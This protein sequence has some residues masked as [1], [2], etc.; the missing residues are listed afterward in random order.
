MMVSPATIHCWKH[1][2]SPSD[3]SCRPHQVRYA[4][5][6]DEQALILSLRQKGLPLDDLADAVQQ[7]LT[8]A[9]RSSIYRLLK[10]NG[11]SCLPK[12]EQQATG[13]TDHY[14]QF[15]DYG[16]GFVHMGCFYL[17]KLEQ[18]KRYCFV[19]IDRATRLCFL[20]VYENKDKRAATDFLKKCLAFFPFR[21]SKLLTDNGREFTPIKPYA[22][23][24]QEPL[25]Q[26]D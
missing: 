18:Q 8:G 1:R 6:D 15:K 19:A 9:T 24:V 10:H 5:D 12:K 4:F 17:P 16:P 14:G 13:Q 22:Q 7:V 25:G 21:I 23:A 26:Q 3:R 2:T 11:K 20:A